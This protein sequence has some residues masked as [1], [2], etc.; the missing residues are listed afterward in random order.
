M[1]EQRKRVAIKAALLTFCIGSGLSVAHPAAADPAHITQ[2]LGFGGDGGNS[3]CYGETIVCTD[4]DLPAYHPWAPYHYIL[5]VADANQ[6]FTVTA[7]V[8]RG[9]KFG[10]SSPGGGGCNDAGTKYT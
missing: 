6:S 7:D 5:T 3:G 2:V 1:L 9:N 4:Y 8:T 10:F